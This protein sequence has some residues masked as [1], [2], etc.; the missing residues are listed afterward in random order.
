MKN[1]ALNLIG[2]NNLSGAAEIIRGYEISADL[3][4][5]NW[6]DQ[7]KLALDSMT[8]TK[9]DWYEYCWQNGELAV[10]T[11]RL[12]AGDNVQTK[13]GKWK[14]S[15]VCTKSTYS[16]NKSVIGNAIDAGV[17][18]MEDGE[19]RG[20]TAVEKD[21]REANPATTKSNPQKFMEALA[22]AEKATEG[23][24]ASELAAALEEIKRF[25]V[26]LAL[27]V[28]GSIINAV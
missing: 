23:M 28:G 19:V 15:M 4:S 8:T 12:Q 5:N 24:T 11:M 17:V 7:V 18:L 13:S 2:E 22:R 9:D 6:S 1:S 27:Q 25:E 3:D 20:K 21:I 14:K 10:L 16:A 26:V